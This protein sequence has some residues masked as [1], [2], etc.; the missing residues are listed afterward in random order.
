MKIN[1]KRKIVFVN[2]CFDILHPGHIHLLKN[3]KNK[4]EY[5]FVG[6]NS[7]KSLKALKGKERPFFS[8]T[9]RK[10]MLLELKSVDEVRIFSDL[11]ALKLLKKI[12]PDIYVK[13][14]D[15]LGKKTPETD[16]MISKNK[17]VFYVKL[18][19]KYS[20]SKIFSEIKSL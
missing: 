15:Y 1:K 7:D 20:T 17:K 9:E 3:A 8:Q 6:L 13:G 18:L 12:K 5:L 2:G 10:K 19:E 14:S 11:N 4:G 16:Y